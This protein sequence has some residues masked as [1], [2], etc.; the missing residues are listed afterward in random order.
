MAGKA[1]DIKIYGDPVLR[2]KAKHVKEVTKEVRSLVGRMWTAMYENKGIGLAAPQVGVTKKVIVVDT[3]EEGEKYAVI[4]PKIVRSS[5]ACEFG[6]EGCLSI[7]GLDG[8]VL[9]PVNV[10]VE[11][12][13]ISGQPV[14]IEASGLLARVFQHEIDHLNGV[15]FV[16]RIPEEQRTKL[17]RTLRGM[18]QKTKESLVVA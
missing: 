7:P 4:N 14:T 1:L 12:V 10:V 17:E 9:R 8:D 15:L 2:R 13:D 5:E 11:G 6:N 16:D 3:R 18:A